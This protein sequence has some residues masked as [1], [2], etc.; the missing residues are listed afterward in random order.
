M[1]FLQIVLQVEN[2]LNLGRLG[3]GG[4][5]ALE[6]INN[7]IKASA[8][9]QGGDENLV[10]NGLTDDQAQAIERMIIEGIHHI[11]K[12]P[13]SDVIDV[14]AQRAFIPRKSPLSSDLPKKSSLATFKKLFPKALKS[15]G[16][17]GVSTLPNPKEE[18]KVSKKEKA[19]QVGIPILQG[20]KVAAPLPSN[21][22]AAK[23]FGAA[24]VG[25]NFGE[26]AR[27]SSKQ[28]RPVPVLKSLAQTSSSRPKKLRSFGIGNAGAG[29]SP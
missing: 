25:R 4:I 3:M 22:A 28:M 23:T 9:V 7:L 13:T 16:S 17:S 14:G 24:A 10:E 15:K 20:K 19:L 12:K 27:V 6:K 1:R 21:K 18:A 26:P 5:K 2:N 11:K 8:D 29:N